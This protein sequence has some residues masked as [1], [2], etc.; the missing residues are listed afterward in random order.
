MFGL[1]AV[2][3]QVDPLA[4]PLEQRLN[5]SLAALMLLLLVGIAAYASTGRTTSRVFI[6]PE[7]V[8][9]WARPGAALSFVLAGLGVLMSLL[10]V[11][12]L[13]DESQSLIDHVSSAAT[14]VYLGLGLRVQWAA[15]SGRMETHVPVVAPTARLRIAVRAAVIA[16]GVA[17]AA[18]GV[19]APSVVR[20]DH[21]IARCRSNDFI[22]LET[23]R[24][25]GSLRGE[26]LQQRIEE[27]TKNLEACSTAGIR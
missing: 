16:I 20:R 24:A 13:F 26:A 14:A 9:A 2:A 23:Q 18:T 6:A 12:S 19:A 17:V 25:L 3:A 21:E 5:M 27:L 4:T 10:V 7:R 1:R 15:A 8:P 11:V 22:H